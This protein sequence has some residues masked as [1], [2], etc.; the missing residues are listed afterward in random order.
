MTTRF[1]NSFVL[2][3]TGLLNPQWDKYIYFGTLPMIFIIVFL[4]LLFVAGWGALFAIN[5]FKEPSSSI[6]L[7]K[8]IDISTANIS[9][10]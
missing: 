2:A 3:V 10:T 4:V 1:E 8:K 7:G 6:I 9:R 5:F